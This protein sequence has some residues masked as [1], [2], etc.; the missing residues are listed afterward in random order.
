MGHDNTIAWPQ[1]KHG[2]CGD[3][4]DAPQKYMIRRP[5]SATFTEGQAIALEVTVSQGHKG[6]FSFAICPNSTADE[7]VTEDCFALK[8]HQLTR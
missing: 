7:A 5:N 6:R 1:G 2:I 3:R 8:Q 4:W